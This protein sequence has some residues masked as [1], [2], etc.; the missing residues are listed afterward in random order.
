MLLKDE[1]SQ[2][3]LKLGCQRWEMIAREILIK[4]GWRE[5]SRIEA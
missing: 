4:F 1:E 5:A 2:E 3:V